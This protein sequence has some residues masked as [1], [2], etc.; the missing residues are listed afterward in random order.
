MTSKNAEMTVSS[1][2]TIASTAQKIFHA[3]TDPAQVPMWWGDP[4]G[5]VVER[6]D[7]DLRVG[8]RWRLKAKG[9]DGEIIVIDGAYRTIEA[10][11]LLEYTWIVDGGPTETLVR[12]D[13]S[14]V[15]G[16]TLVQ[17]THTGFVDVESRD[18]HQRGWDKVLVW[19]RQYVV[20]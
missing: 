2:I 11:H 5:F 13:L 15:A 16:G 17:V 8:G 14:E 6:F 18:Q 9:S 10:P 12:F 3:L 1:E 19:I 20:K 4:D 7:G